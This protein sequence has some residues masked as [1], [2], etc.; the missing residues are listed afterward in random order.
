MGLAL[1]AARAAYAAPPAQDP[2]AREFDYGLSEMQAG[3]Y[4]TGCPSLAESYKL[5]PRPGVLFTLAECEKRW[6]KSATALANYEAYIAQFDRM[7]GEQKRQQVGRDSLA[8]AA[9]DALRKEVPMLTV[10]LPASAPP[11]TIVQRD[12]E[13]LG[14]PSLGVP[15]PVDPGEHVVVV[16]TP[17]GATADTHV[18]LA[19]GDHT[20]LTLELPKAS[21]KA[22]LPSPPPPTP[23]SRLPFYVAGGIGL[24]GIAVGI[25]SGIL[26][27]T[28][29]S[30]I[31]AGCGIGGNAHMCTPAGK[32]A[33]DTGQTEALVST[34]GFGVG[35]AGLGTAVVLRLME[36]AG[37]G[38]ALSASARW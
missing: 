9:R 14:T 22:P 27:L 29:K 2:A 35:L 32:S 17:D 37:G 33:V 19:P 8:A 25:V 4:A 16:R 34:I 6:G 38:L 5:D 36:P 15:L 13:T 12:D 20:Q 26:A 3:R 18:T 28:E 7:S 31:D 21:P 10:S 30:S 24:T 23:R 1:I 11:G